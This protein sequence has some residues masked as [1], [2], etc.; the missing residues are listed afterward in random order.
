MSSR[1]SKICS[2]YT[3]VIPWTDILIESV[4]IPLECSLIRSKKIILDSSKPFIRCILNN[5]IIGER[6]SGILDSLSTQGKDR[7][8]KTIFQRPNSFFVE[9]R[10]SQ[11]QQF[12]SKAYSSHKKDPIKNISGKQ[13]Q[14][15]IYE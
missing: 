4:Q 3:Y 7:M 8:W 5:H 11:S 12:F 10:V 15:F 14:L 9:E 1:L 2:V 6:C 13:N